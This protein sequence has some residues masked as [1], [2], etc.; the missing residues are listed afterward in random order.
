VIKLR[1]KK[2]VIRKK[3][4]IN[5]KSEPHRQFGM[6]IMTEEQY[7]LDSE[8]FSKL[9]RAGR[10]VGIKG[11]NGKIEIIA[12]TRQASVED[13]IESKKALESIAQDLG[14]PVKYLT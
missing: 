13:L 7:R 2:Q 6:V 8:R 3:Q 11:P 12:G 1:S 10:Q 9:R 5:K 4:V 14:L